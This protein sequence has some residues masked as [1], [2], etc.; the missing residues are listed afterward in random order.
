MVA[1]A[2]ARGYSRRGMRLSVGMLLLAVGLAVGC[3]AEKQ[4]PVVG[5]DEITAAHL[6]SLRED[7]SVLRHLEPTEEEARA[8][9]EEAAARGEG[10]GAHA[11]G[12]EGWAEDRD[13]EE[14]PTTQEKWEQASI[15]VLQVAVTVGAMVAPYFL[16]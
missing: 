1:A 10:A 7:D 3:G 13:L 14:E 8:L 12:E 2:G 6:R 9:A 4:R 11:A 15:A 16:F 5:E